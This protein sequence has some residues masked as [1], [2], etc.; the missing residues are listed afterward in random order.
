M[1]F[2]AGG[3]RRGAR[4]APLAKFVLDVPLAGRHALPGWHSALRAAWGDDFSASPDGQLALEL[5]GGGMARSTNSNYDSKVRQFLEFCGQ[6]VPVAN[7]LAADEALFIEYVAWHARRGRVRMTVKNFQPY[8]SAIN[9]LYKAVKSKIFAGG[10]KVCDA[11]KAAGR[12]Q[13]L[14]D[15]GARSLPRTFLPA[16]VAL[17]ILERAEDMVSCLTGEFD[18]PGELLELLRPLLATVNS[19]LWFDRPH[20]AVGARWQDFGLGA[21]ELLFF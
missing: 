18:D 14:A 20:T 13:R 19:F 17:S 16:P 3:G 15:A 4:R 6:R 7:P 21:A 1:G 5:V 12:R 8:L 2:S 9:K 11:T 10:E